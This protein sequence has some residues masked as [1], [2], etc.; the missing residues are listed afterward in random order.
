MVAVAATH[1]D[2][3]PLWPSEAAA[4]VVD[5]SEAAMTVYTGSPSGRKSRPA[6]SL[7]LLDGELWIDGHKL[8]PGDY[9]R[10]EAP[11]RD[12]SVFTSSND[13]LV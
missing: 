3:H 9:S 5:G 6:S 4:R 10:A 7:H 8:H 2:T 12:A 13:I 1:E 11:S